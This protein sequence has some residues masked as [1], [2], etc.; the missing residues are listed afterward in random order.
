MKRDMI[1][2]I[3]SIEVSTQRLKWIFINMQ[4]L[5]QIHESSFQIIMQELLL[6]TDINISKC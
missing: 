5:N 4:T 3:I 6:K 1:L 2:H